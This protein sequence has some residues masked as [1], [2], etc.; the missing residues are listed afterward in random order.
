MGERQSL[1][2]KFSGGTIKNKKKLLAPFL[3][4]PFLLILSI[5]PSYRI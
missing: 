2:W 1:G 5:P 4:A 3:V